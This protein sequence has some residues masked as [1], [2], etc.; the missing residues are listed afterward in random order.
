MP[1]NKNALL[2]TRIERGEALQFLFERLVGVHHP[3]LN[4]EEKELFS[5]AKS[6]LPESIREF[7]RVVRKDSIDRAELV[8][9]VDDLL[10]RVMSL[11]NYLPAFPHR[12]KEA[13]AERTSPA[14]K[15]GLEKRQRLITLRRSLLSN[16]KYN[17]SAIA[18]S[19][20]EAEA[21][22]DEFKK[23]LRKA[24]KKEL[25][26]VNLQLSKEGRAEENR[27]IWD[28]MRL[29]QDPKAGN[30]SPKTLQNDARALL[31]D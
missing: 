12:Q 17:L 28:Q 21:I 19:T 9:A 27:V 25:T 11:G 24:I 6:A 20:K 30:P 29:L 26:A 23:E 8:T 16:P 18:K 2:N 10:W 22:S 31:V 5:S 4:S 1:T 3:S 14:R 7:N 13:D 15:V